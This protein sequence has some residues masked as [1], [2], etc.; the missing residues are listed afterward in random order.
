VTIAV[1]CAATRWM[2]GSTQGSKV[3]EDDIF[4]LANKQQNTMKKTIHP[5]G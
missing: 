2:M 3:K 5:S 4:V 1:E